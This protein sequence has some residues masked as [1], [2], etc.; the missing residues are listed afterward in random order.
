MDILELVGNNLLETIIGVVVSLVGIV[1]TA[2]LTKFKQ[3]VKF[4]IQ[5]SMA[6]DKVTEAVRRVYEEYVREIKKASAD[7]KLTEEE[8]ANARTMAL[9]YTLEIARGTEVESFVGSLSQWAFHALIE[10]AVNS[11]KPSKT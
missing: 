1:A 7:G 6:F 10:K 5:T 9:K 8:K 3:K 4:D 2:A 11:L